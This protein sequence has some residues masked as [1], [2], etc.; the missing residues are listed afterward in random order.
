MARALERSGP[1]QAFLPDLPTCDKIIPAA[2]KRDPFPGSP[3]S[4]LPSSQFEPFSSKPSK[5]F[6]K[7]LLVPALC[8]EM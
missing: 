7:H 1:A 5:T 6:V 4:T 2:P 8:Q 3:T